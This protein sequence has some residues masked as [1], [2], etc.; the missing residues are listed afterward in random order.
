MPGWIAALIYLACTLVMG[1][2][3]FDRML[4]GAFG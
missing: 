2:V 1:W 3:I 4:P